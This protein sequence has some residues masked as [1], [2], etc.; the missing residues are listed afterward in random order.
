MD[1]A[2]YYLAV[3]VQFRAPCSSLELVTLSISHDSRRRHFNLED[4]FSNRQ[5]VFGHTPK[6]GPELHETTS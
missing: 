4:G 5:K 2:Y 1:A 6:Q 3:T